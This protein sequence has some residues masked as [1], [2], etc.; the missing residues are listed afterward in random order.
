MGISAEE[1]KHLTP[2]K[3]EYCVKGYNMRRKMHDEEMWMW[4][5]NYGISAISVAVEHCFAGKSAK[6]TYVKKHI[7]DMDAEQEEANTYKEKQEEVA[8]F[9][10]KQRIELLRK[11]GLPESPM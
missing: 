9:E 5:G 3:L 7:M 8:I 1:F 2:A 6:S 10:M 11:S 4:W